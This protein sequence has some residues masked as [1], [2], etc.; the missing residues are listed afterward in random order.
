MHKV[1]DLLAVRSGKVWSVSPQASVLEALKLMAEKDIGAVL[2]LEGADLVG[3]FSERDYAREAGR[4]GKVSDDATVSDLM[5]SHVL[6]VEPGARLDECMALMTEKHVRHLPVVAKGKVVGIVTIGDV[7]K[8]I[9][10]KQRISLK[11]MV[12]YIRGDP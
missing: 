8:E 2:V 3:I 10:T 7:V 6:Y 4:A 12:R 5:S 9:I 11:K 1:K